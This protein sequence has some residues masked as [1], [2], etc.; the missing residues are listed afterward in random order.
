M[1]KAGKRILQAAKEG[2]AI[3]ESEV[4]E[5]TTVQN[6]IM[7]RTETVDFIEELADMRKLGYN[8]K[9]EFEKVPRK[10]P[11]RETL[12]GWKKELLSM[13]RSLFP[14]FLREN[15]V[16]LLDSFAHGE[17]PEICDDA[18]KN[19]GRPTNDGIVL[20]YIRVAVGYLKAVD[21]KKIIDKK[22]VERISTHYKVHKKT[23][24]IWR[25]KYDPHL[26]AYDHLSL[27]QWQGLIEKE[28]QIFQ[29]LRPNV[30]KQ[31]FES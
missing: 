10:V 8:I 1:T 22:P 12:R 5:G 21:D 4:V 7:D 29:K 6:S 11:A 2:L 19:K 28:G 25:K 23:V 27:V 9:V 14:G 13:D 16:N 31:K 18:I 17:I 30:T 26:Y 24:R 20:P 3:A 15:L